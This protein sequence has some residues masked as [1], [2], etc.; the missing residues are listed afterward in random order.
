MRILVLSDA[1]GAVAP[2]LRA[3][4]AHPEARDIFYLGDGIASLEDLP[5]QYPG[6]R[7][8]FVRGNNDFGCDF[9]EECLLELGGIHIFATHGHRY[10][11]YNGYG[12]LMQRARSL[13]AQV[14]LCGHTHVAATRF[15]DGVTLLNPGSIAHS[16][17]GPASYGGLDII[18][19]GIVPLIFPANPKQSDGRKHP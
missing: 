8:T 17:S 1:H 3:I 18:P 11:L 7:F 15:E 10:G 12:G 14:A 5:L 2:V 13:G 19:T 4:D 9:P 6:R 16:R